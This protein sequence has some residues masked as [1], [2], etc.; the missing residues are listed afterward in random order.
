[1]LLAPL[2]VPLLRVLH[3][4]PLP[5]AF[6]RVCPPPP[7]SPFSEASSLYRIRHILSHW[8]QTR[9]SVLCYICLVAL[10]PALVFSLV[11]GLVSPSSLASTLVVNVGITMGLAILFVYFV[12]CLIKEF[13][14]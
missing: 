6:E 8:G 12:I 3:S 5:F 10:V 4:I 14:V 13:S 11:G 7:T 2:L 9:Q 1:M